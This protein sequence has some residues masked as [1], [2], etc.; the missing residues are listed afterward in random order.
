MNSPNDFHEPGFAARHGRKALR[1]AGLAAGGVV[2]AVLFA[3]LFGLAVKAL[4]NWLMPAIFG[5]GPITFWQAFGLVLLAKILFGGHAH[6]R[7]GHDDRFE[8][9][10]RSGFKRFAGPGGDAAKE[11]S[12]P[13]GPGSWRHFRGFW[14]EEGKAAFE[15][16]L[17]KMEDRERGGSPS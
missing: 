1:I 8:K 15:A 3:F 4:W 10:F 6:G 14:Q 16:Y 13:D 5:L 7:G 17:R 12:L 9:R 11:G 2:F